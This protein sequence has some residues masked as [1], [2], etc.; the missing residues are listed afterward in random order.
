[1]CRFIL[2]LCLINR[3]HLSVHS[4]V[5]YLPGTCIGYMYIQLSQHTN[6]LQFTKPW[7]VTYQC[8]ARGTLLVLQSHG[9]IVCHW[10]RLYWVNKVVHF[11]WLKDTYTK[12][13]YTSEIT[14]TQAFSIH[15]VTFMYQSE[16]YCHNNSTSNNNL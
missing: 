6:T 2:Y 9:T 1:M 13:M 16:S 4:I 11:L 7:V 10:G 5:V 12:H 14:N 3:V 15:N 8:V